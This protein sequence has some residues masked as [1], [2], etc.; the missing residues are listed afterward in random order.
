MGEDDAAAT[1][2]QTVNASFPRSARLLHQED[3]RRVFRGSLRFTDAFFTVL[4]HRNSLEVA[5]LGLSIP[6][7]CAKKAVA[8]NRLKRVIREEFRTHRQALMGQDILV[9]CRPKA[10]EATKDL[11]ASALLKHWQ[12]IIEDRPCASS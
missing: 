1:I 7:K 12:A 5:R 3:Y 9:L 11:L 8:R 10:A 2:T 4:A 6:K